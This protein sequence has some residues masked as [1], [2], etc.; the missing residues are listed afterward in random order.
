MRRYLAPTGASG[1]ARQEFVIA[2]L[3]TVCLAAGCR[4]ARD[5]AD[6]IEEGTAHAPTS[7]D[8]LGLLPDVLHES[9]G[10]AV[11]RVHPGIFW[12][13]NDSG[14]RPRFFAVD[15]TAR[16]IGIW[17]VADAK[18]V[19][20]E[21]LDVGPCPE[22]EVAASSSCLY[23]A[24]MG[25]NDR[26]RTEHTVYV[27]AEPDPADTTRTV[28][29][30]GR[31]RFRYPDVAHDA[32]ALAVHP[33]GDLVV[34]SKG[35][36]DTI[37]LYHLSPGELAGDV[38]ADTTVTLPPG[39]VLPIGPDWSV[40]RVVTGGSFNPAGDVLVVRTYSEIYFYRWPIRGAPVEAD[41]TCFLGDLEPQ[42]E[43][44]A[45][46]GADALVLTSE[47]AE[48]RS[49]ALLRVKCRGVG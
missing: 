32:E 31:L 37:L 21:D 4:Q 3:L 33:S 8:T 17:N 45:F 22:S 19:D 46:Q 5:M 14:D 9:S 15:S 40:G 43:A 48:G 24:D 10:V 26:Q 47:R 39:T 13:H 20:W 35:R 23:L 29:P 7:V 41:T 38:E 28:R 1:A 34:V 11:S 16:V 36:T 6:F 49:G 18:A 12:T 25:D 30:L 27:V 42:G 2:L 44:V